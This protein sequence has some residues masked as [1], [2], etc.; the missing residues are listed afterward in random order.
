MTMNMRAGPRADEI[1]V[2]KKCNASIM[3]LKTRSGGW[4]PVNVMP[5]KNDVRGPNS[6]ET[7][8]IFGEHQSH[9]STCPKADSFRRDR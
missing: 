6:G 7:L 2:C 9:F 5:T 1:T 8:F 3:F 4:M